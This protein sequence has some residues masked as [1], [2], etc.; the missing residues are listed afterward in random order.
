M[1]SNNKIKI[2]L[3]FNRGGRFKFVSVKKK[4]KQK[5]ASGC[6]RFTGQEGIFFINFFACF[7]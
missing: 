7:T 5:V 2:F 3:I 4:I 1:K 6:P